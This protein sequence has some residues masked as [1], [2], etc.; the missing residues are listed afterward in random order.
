MRLDRYEVIL[1]VGPPGA[2]KGTQARAVC[3]RLRIPH[4]ASGDLLRAHRRRGTALGITIRAAMDAGDLVPDDLVLSMVVER[5]ARH[6]A[7]HGALLDGFP[8]TLAQAQALDAALAERGGG[9]R[10]VLT[11]DV[12]S[13][14]LIARLAGRRVCLGCQTTFHVE[15]QRLPLDGTCPRCGDALVRRPDD[16]PTV[17]AHRLDL[18]AAETA[19]VVD[20]YRGLE[21]VRRIDGARPID[22]IQDEIAGCVRDEPAVL[23][24]T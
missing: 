3:D 11:I 9:V 15:A 6:D 18:Y 20:H 8:R 17:V 19:P 16:A 4:V 14:I 24:A 5:L 12:P 2:G 7:A 1:L 10:L 23:A 21:L 13:D 22:E